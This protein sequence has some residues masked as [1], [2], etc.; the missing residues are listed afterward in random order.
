MVERIRLLLSSPYRLTPNTAETAR[1]HPK[2]YPSGP[3]SKRPIPHLVLPIKNIKNQ[4]PGL[5][6]RRLNHLHIP[7]ER[8]Q[9]GPDDPPRLLVII[10]VLEKHLDAQVLVGPLPEDDDAV[11]AAGVDL[12]ARGGEG[13]VDDVLDGAP[14]VAAGQGPRVEEGDVGLRV[15]GAPDDG[16]GGG[17]FGFDVGASGEGAVC[18]SG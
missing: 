14:G 8:D 3:H 13:G 6:P 1:R 18:E 12:L 7:F 11:A 10:R 17:Q 2:Y 15:G 5:P 4:R 16:V 9:R